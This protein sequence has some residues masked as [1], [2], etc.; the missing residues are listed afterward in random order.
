L[1]V[2]LLIVLLNVDLLLSQGMSRACSVSTPLCPVYT[3][4]DMGLSK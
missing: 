2:P 3:V 4:V 1:S